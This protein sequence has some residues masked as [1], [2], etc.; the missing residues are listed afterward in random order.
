[1]AKVLAAYEHL[2]EEGNIGPILFVSLLAIA[3]QI[4]LERIKKSDELYLLT[5]VYTIDDFLHPVYPYWEGNRSFSVLF[6]YLQTVFD[7]IEKLLR[8]Y[9]AYWE[10]IHV[11]SDPDFSNISNDS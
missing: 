3:F 9:H 7:A 6:E 4:L 10:E 2:A 1:M 8:F 11:F 5:V